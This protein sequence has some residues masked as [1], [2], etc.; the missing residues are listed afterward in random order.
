MPEVSAR[1]HSGTLGSLPGPPFPC[2]KSG[3]NDSP[4]LQRLNEVEPCLACGDSKCQVIIFVSAKVPH[5][6]GNSSPLFLTPPPCGP[7]SS[8][9]VHV[10]QLQ[11]PAPSSLPKWLLMPTLQGAAQKSAHLEFCCSCGACIMPGAY[12]STAWHFLGIRDCLVPGPSLHW[13]L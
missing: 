11:A 9:P 3:G 7:V 2:W 8:H 1:T 6:L 10:S 4:A 5:H 13:G 12:T